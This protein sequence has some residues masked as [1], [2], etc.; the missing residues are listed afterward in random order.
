MN[1]F[2]I[3]SK[4]NNKEVELVKQIESNKEYIRK[5]EE[6]INKLENI[7]FLQAEVVCQEGMCKHTRKYVNKNKLIN[8]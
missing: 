8:V 1:I 3:F 5:L 7:Y 4:K 2:G 6:Q